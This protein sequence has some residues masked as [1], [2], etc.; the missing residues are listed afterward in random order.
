MNNLPVPISSLEEFERLALHMCQGL[1]LGSV[2]E[3]MLLLVTAG[4]RGTDVL[5]LREN[6]N[7]MFGQLSKRADAMLAQFQRDGGSYVIVE[8][9]ATRAALTASYGDNKDVFFELTWADAINEPFVYR[10]NQDTQLAQ[11]KKPFEQ[12][13]LKARYSTPPARTQMQWARL[14]SDMVRALD[15][16]AVVGTYTPE[17]IEDFA[18]PVEQMDP[19]AVPEDQAFARAQV[20]EAEIVPAVDYSVCPQIGRAH[21]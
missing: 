7:F 8:R 9:S 19:V 3:G 20:V 16:N 10:G 12:R 1:Q 6:Y 17:E 2:G 18:G 21:V 13:S 4:Q 5:T 15:P 14:C 11:L